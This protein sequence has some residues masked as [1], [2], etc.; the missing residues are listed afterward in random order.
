M[1]KESQPISS[2]RTERPIRFIILSTSVLFIF[3]VVL[4]IIAFYPELNSL[5][6]K[7]VSGQ[8]ENQIIFLKSKLSLFF[9]CV[10]FALI[11][12]FGISWFLTGRLL[13]PINDIEEQLYQTFRKDLTSRI[14]IPPGHEQAKLAEELNQFIEEFEKTILRLRLE[15]EEVA[16]ILLKAKNESH[17]QST[18]DALDRIAKHNEKIIEMLLRY[19]VTGDQGS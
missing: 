3:C 16:Q 17:V 10:I 11:G 1:P 18:K 15:Q 5:V 2:S 19:Q 4:L 7:G 8:D 14:S 6:N 12:S 9:L 13:A